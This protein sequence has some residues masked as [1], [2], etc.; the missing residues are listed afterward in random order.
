MGLLLLAGCIAHAGS[1]LA[2]GVSE[3]ATPEAQKAYDDTFKAMLADPLDLDRAF[4]YAQAAIQV[5]DLEGAISALERML[6]INPELPRVRLELGVLYFRLGSYVAAQTYFNSVGEM[7]DVPQPVRERVA[8]F[9][10][11]IAKRQSRHAWS[12]SLFFGARSQSNANTATATGAVMVGG[13]NA[14]LD[15]QFTQKQD[16]NIFAALN[17]KHTYEIDPTKTDTWDTALS[18]Y[19]SRQAA[20]KQV[21]VSLIE[22]TSGPTLVLAPGTDYDPRLRPYAILSYIEINDVRDYFAPG[23]G[24]SFTSVL[25]PRMQGELSSEFRD[26]RFKDDND[27]PNKSDKDGPEL[28]HR[29]RLT[30]APFDFLSFN[31]GAG[32]TVQ[33]AR[34]ESE[35]NTEY[36]LTAGMTVSYPSPLPFLQMPWAT[37][38]SV[39]RAYTKYDRPDPTISAV[40][41]RQDKDWRMSVT[42]AVPLSQDWALVA[43]AAR[44]IRSST[45]PNFEY[46]NDSIMIGA[47]VRF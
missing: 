40:E 25:S 28:T 8:M 13:I 9:Q 37:I 21:D 30:F 1:P 6:F 12:G 11:E 46:H 34:E 10:A 7:K 32:M 4:A 15:S 45:L 19:V 22:I 47:N 5:G 26:R 3:A 18:S 2:Q 35:A 24:M 14:N 42:Q 38:G 43:T 39:T 27:S 23:I 44:T 17:L 31:A 33:N 41:R 29:A 36:S 20:Q 16:N